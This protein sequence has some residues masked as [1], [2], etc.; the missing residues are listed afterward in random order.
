MTDKPKQ[1]AKLTGRELLAIEEALNARLAGEIDIAGEPG[2]PRRDD[3]QR[4]LDK[5]ARMLG[6]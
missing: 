5:I 1:A 3:Y 2:A 6:D 4:A